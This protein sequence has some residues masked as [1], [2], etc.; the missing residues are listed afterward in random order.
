V[1][2]TSGANGGAAIGALLVLVAVGA[3]AWAG[4]RDRAS[5]PPDGADPQQEQC[6]VDAV[7]AASVEV[8]GA[9]SVRYGTLVLR[10]SPR[11]HAA[12]PQFISTVQVPTGATVHLDAAR[13][14]LGTVRGF[15]FA[16][17]IAPQVY[18]VYGNLL[19]TTRGCVAASV[20]VLAAGDQHQLATAT[21]P[22]LTPDQPA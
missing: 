1:T 8:V 14:A 20:D 21:T 17:L 13:P 3:V 6:H 15:D 5:G 16:Y 4:L 9:E 12:W 11:C 2:R 10:Y 7:N 22:C 18:S 19:R